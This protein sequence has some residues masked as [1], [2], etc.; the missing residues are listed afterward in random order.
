RGRA[1]ARGAG[2]LVL[3]A[4][5][6]ACLRAGAEAGA[7]GVLAVAAERR[8][9]T[10]WIQV[11][12]TLG[13]V[14]AEGTTVLVEASDDGG[15]TWDVPVLS[16]Q[17]DA[18]PVGLRTPGGRFTWD[19]GADAPGLLAGPW[20]VRV[21]AYPP[22]Q[23]PPAGEMVPVPA[24]PFPM[25]STSGDLHEAPVHRPWLDGF[26]ID[27][28]EVTNRDFARFAQATRYRTLAE[29]EGASVVYVEGAYRT[30]RGASWRAPDGVGS[31][32]YGRLD[33][34]VVQVAWQ[35]AQ[36]FCRWAGKRLPTEAEWEKAARGPEGRTYPWGEEAPDAGGRYRANYGT[37]ECC[38]PSDLDGFLHTAPVGAFPLGVSP[39]GIHDLGGNVWEWTADFYGPE[40]Y[41]QS[42]GRDPAGPPQAA[43]RVL[44]GGSWVSPPFR[45]RASY[46][47]HHPE[48]TRHH[49]GGF[50]CARSWD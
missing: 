4:A 34:P 3:A 33:H 10:L 41:A 19:A 46:R 11:A 45:L 49:Y 27:R 24:G 5:C 21:S 38:G 32:L 2:L 44:R 25:G 15:R 39:Y 26:R 29:R 13:G 28:F 30:V 22:G 6:A 50:R 9:G 18:G 8:P 7:P 47:G 40:Y 20:Q 37:N 16:L 43:E 17:G 12:Y 35:D 42:P 36:A 14:P 23:R 1:G 48:E 31:G